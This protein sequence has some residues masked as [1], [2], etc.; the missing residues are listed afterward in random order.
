MCLVA[1]MKHIFSYH[2]AY[3]IDCFLYRDP[4]KFLLK[5]DFT[6]DSFFRLSICSI[7]DPLSI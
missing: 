3:K 7:Y 6:Q 4:K 2:K 5:E 1:P